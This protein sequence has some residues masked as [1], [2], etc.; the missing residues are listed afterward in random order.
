MQ[1]E[2]LR[3]PRLFWAGSISYMLDN[4]VLPDDAYNSTPMSPN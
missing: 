3:P 1:G 4:A 2:R